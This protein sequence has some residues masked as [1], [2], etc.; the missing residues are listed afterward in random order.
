M[1][2]QQHKQATQLPFRQIILARLHKLLL[3]VTSAKMV[4][5]GITTWLLV[6]GTVSDIVWSGVVL[7]LFAGRE[8]AK[9]QHEQKDSS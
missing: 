6:A 7:G 9:R 5:I 4:F 2:K 8:H 1:P 3:D